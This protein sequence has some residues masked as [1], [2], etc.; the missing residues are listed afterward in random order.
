MKKTLWVISPPNKQFHCYYFGLPDGNWFA[1]DPKNVM[2]TGELMEKVPNT[3]LNKQGYELFKLVAENPYN[4]WEYCYYKI[5][6]TNIGDVDQI[7]FDLDNDDIV[8]LFPG[9]EKL[10]SSNTLYQH[11]FDDSSTEPEPENTET[12]LVKDKIY[13]VCYKGETSIFDKLIRIIKTNL[14][15]YKGLEFPPH[16]PYKLPP[17]RPWKGAFIPPLHKPPHAKNLLPKGYPIHIYP[18]PF[19][20]ELA[21]ILNT[22]YTH[23][24]LYIPSKNESNPSEITYYACRE[25]AGVMEYTESADD[26]VLYPINMHT[27]RPDAIRHFFKH[28][29]FMRGS[30]IGDMGYRI[31]MHEHS[32]S[33]VEWVA[34]ALNLGFPHKYTINKLIEFSKLED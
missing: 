3:Y 6:D 5:S 12:D 14:V 27:V 26:L 17:P 4:S 16:R 23:V 11:I 18:K 2:P 7:P 20:H 30:L 15:K 13:L 10:D 34:K 9:F 22:D 28:T 19:E 33:S 31:L 1:N 21:R 29:Q 32:M 8:H 25:D 24:G